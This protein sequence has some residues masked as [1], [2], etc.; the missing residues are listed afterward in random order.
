VTRMPFLGAAGL[1]GY[2]YIYSPSRHTNHKNR[3]YTPTCNKSVTSCE[4]H[5]SMKYIVEYNESGTGWE[6]KIFHGGKVYTVYQWISGFKHTETEEEP[7]LE[8]K[9]KPKR[10]KYRKRK[11]SKNTRQLVLQRD[12]HRCTVCGKTSSLHVHHIMYRAL[13][14]TDDL[15]NLTTLCG[16]C[17]CKAHEGQPVSRIMRKRRIPHAILQGGGGV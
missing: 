6:K 16:E 2:R 9:E 15:Q 4:I 14:G 12:G 1:R 8:P 7:Q 10:R 11:T 3:R 17:H 5:P 13:G